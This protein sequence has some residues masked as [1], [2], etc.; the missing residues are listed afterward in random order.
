[1]SVPQQGSVSSVLLDAFVECR[2][3]LINLATGILGCRCLAEDA[4]HDAFLRLMEAPYDNSIR[5]PTSYLFRIVRNLAIDGA[6]RAVFESRHTCPEEDASLVG[7]PTGGPE[8]VAVDR[9]AL[10]TVAQALEGLPERT[11]AA[12]TMHRL[13]GYTQKEVAAHLGV[14]PTLVNFMVRDAHR[15]CHEVFHRYAQTGEIPS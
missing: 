6:R 15:Y 4:V 9:E 10:G 11:R 3:S 13:D 2:R 12:F 8:E 7:A 14:S 5:H 1:M